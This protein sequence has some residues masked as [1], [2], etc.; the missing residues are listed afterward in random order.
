MIKNSA[1]VL[2]LALIGG[3]ARAENHFLAELAGGPAT[4]LGQ[5]AENEAAVGGSLTIGVGG[6][7]VGHRAAYYLV[8]RAG[9]S[10]LLQTG[11]AASG[12]PKVEREDFELLLGPRAYLPLVGHLRLCLQVMAGETF[13]AAT[14]SRVHHPNLEVVSDHATFLAGV[15]LQY[16]LHENVSLGA[17]LE[18]VAFAQGQ[19][20]DVAARAAGL[21]HD[22]ARGRALASLTA[23]VHF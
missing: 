10:T 14:V 6:R 15:G 1:L 17:G 11:S 13:E 20:G 4:A 19:T 18:A 2:C 7:F 16:R 8:G 22:G 23:T 5:G 21:D 12:H 9:S 3:E